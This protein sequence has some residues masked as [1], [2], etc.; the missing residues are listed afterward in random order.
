MPDDTDLQL[1][2]FR[3]TGKATRQRRAE[4]LG[5]YT[6]LRRANIMFKKA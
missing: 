2:Q 5:R 3:D 4:K 1:R 6:I